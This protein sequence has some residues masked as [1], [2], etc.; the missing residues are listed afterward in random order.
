MRHD[1]LSKEE[2]SV[3]VSTWTQLKG[4]LKIIKVLHLECFCCFWWKGKGSSSNFRCRWGRFSRV[5]E[6]HVWRGVVWDWDNGT[7]DTE[8]EG[9][10]TRISV[11]GGLRGRTDIWEYTKIHWR[12][13]GHK[14]TAA[15][16]ERSVLSLHCRLWSCRWIPPSGCWE[17]WNSNDSASVSGDTN[18]PN[19]ERKLGSHPLSPEGPVCLIFR[20]VHLYGFQD[21]T[22]TCS[23]PSL[24]INRCEMSGRRRQ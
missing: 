6:R 18:T 9:S 19:I 5:Q 20:H 17:G 8:W 11:W 21:C 7:W 15:G 12:H 16:P 2:C 10:R 22:A 14:T 3:W 13:C 24:S 23:I 1:A 4:L